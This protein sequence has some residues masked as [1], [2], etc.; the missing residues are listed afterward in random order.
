MYQCAE[1]K[2]LPDV[3]L[4]VPELLSDIATL[5]QYGEI[6]SKEQTKLTQECMRILRTKDIAPI[7]EEL[8]FIKRGAILK[9]RIEKMIEKLAAISAAEGENNG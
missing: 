4:I 1:T 5:R 2:I 7:K 8:E 3:R 6:S 9:D